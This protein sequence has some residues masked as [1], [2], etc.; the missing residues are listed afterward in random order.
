MPVPTSESVTPRRLIRDEV[1]ERLLTAIIDGSLTPGEQL[2][3]TEIE[4]WVGVSRT[5]V[6]EALN[7]LATMGLVEILPQK[8]TRVTAIDPARLA[9][10]IDTLSVLHASAA[11]DVTPFLTT[12]DIDHL[13]RTAADST[14]LSD[15]DA[16]AR[17][18]LFTEGFVSVFL[19]R[20]DNATLA[21]LFARYV[22]LV[23][24]ALRAAPSAYALEK[25]SDHLAAII[26]AAEARDADS[27]AL[28]VAAYWSEGIGTVINELTVNEESK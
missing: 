9:G 12:G 5:P 21:R 2:Y 8:K 26:D 19:R 27:V 14:H 15:I 10:L 17:D 1:F 20:L 16:S 18:E 23:R 6:R 24:R 11:H 13:R 4:R 28:S 7:Q 3:D 25:A 22:P